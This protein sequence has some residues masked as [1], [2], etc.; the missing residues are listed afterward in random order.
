LYSTTTENKQSI[1]AT[2]FQADIAL[3]DS[4]LTLS[5]PAKLT[6][7]TGMDALTHAIESYTSTHANEVTKAIALEAI[8]AIGRGL[9]PACENGQDR[10]A[11]LAMAKG[12]VLAGMAFAQTGVGIAHAISHPLGAEFHIPHGVANAILLPEAIRFNRAVCE[13]DYETI[14]KALG[15]E[16]AEK[17]LRQWLEILPLPKTLK[18]AGYEPG[19]E[20]SILDKTFLSRSLKKN[21]REASREDVLELIAWCEGR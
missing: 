5:M 2:W 4:D 13:S 12:S 18:E 17:G 19:R 9:I 6:A 21:P 16:D 8:E 14:A 15:L 3:V 7:A 1:A 11:R 20:A 10:E